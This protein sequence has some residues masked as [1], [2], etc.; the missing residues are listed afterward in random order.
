MRAK[1]D[2]Q[3]GAGDAMSARRQAFGSGDTAAHLTPEVVRNVV[4]AASDITLHLDEN[5]I[6]RAVIL[7]EGSDSFGNLDHWVKRPVTEFLTDE[8][9]AKFED[10]HAQFLSGG[11]V[12]KL[13]ELNHR[14]NAS[15]EFPVR[16][17]FVRLGDSDQALLV[18]RDLRPIAETQQQLVQAQIALEKGYEARREFDARYRV[19]LNS[20]R[21]AV[22]FVSV[23]DGRVKDLNDAA[24][25]LLGMGREQL[26]GAPFANAFKDRTSGELIESLL[27]A[28]IADGDEGLA[29]SSQ[30]GRRQLRIRPTV[31]RAAGERIVLCRIEAVG[32]DQSADDALTGGLLALFRDGSDAIIFTDAKG[33]ITAANDAF[34]ELIDAAHAATVKGRSLGDFLHR[35]Q[36]DL[37]MLLDNSKRSGQMRIY[38]TKLVNDFGSRLSAEISA[39]WITTGAQPVAAFIIRDVSRVEAVRQPATAASEE[40]SRNVMEL[41]GSATLKEI[42]AETTDV[43]EKMCI[44]TAVNLTRNNRVAAAEMLGLSRQSLY[45][46]L[47][48]YGLLNKGQDR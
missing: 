8:S 5:A 40:S 43:V 7:S 39:A 45:V 47:R 12:R 17:A 10:A 25:A 31:F 34:L 21:E 41:V 16:Y 11:D 37:S 14:D 29:V 2:T 4:V 19:L 18:G 35:G 6:I 3:L 32:E 20:V 24:A 46:K 9:I 38:T 22:V 44:E 48:K 1:V 26:S 23:R 27:N 33:T 28:S 42:V 30:T 36:I 13:I 15:W